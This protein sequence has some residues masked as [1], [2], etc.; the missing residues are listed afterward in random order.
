MHRP[1]HQ[2]Y[3]QRAATF[4][5]PAAKQ[6]LEI[7]AKKQTNLA[8]SVDVTKAEEFLAI[9]DAVGPSVCLVKV[10]FLSRASFCG[11][12]AFGVSEDTH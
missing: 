6:L 11:I 3:S 1:Q 12:D 7:M 2:T 10:L 4:S 9:I 8:V 5:N